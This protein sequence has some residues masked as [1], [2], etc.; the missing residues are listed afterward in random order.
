[1]DEALAPGIDGWAEDD[2]AF[3][4]PWGVDLGAISVPIQVWQGGQ[5]L[6]VPPAHG[7]WLARHVRGAEAHLRPDDGHLTLTVQRVGEVHA[8]FAGLLS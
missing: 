1:M 8:W 7:A 5:D 4:A 3:V 6:M 2:L